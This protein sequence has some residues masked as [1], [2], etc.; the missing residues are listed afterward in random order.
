VRGCVRAY[1]G[2]GAARFYCCVISQQCPRLP[3]EAAPRYTLK[4]LL[5]GGGRVYLMSW[6]RVLQGWVCAYLM[7]WRS[8][9]RP[10][11]RPVLR[12]EQEE[13]GREEG[14]IRVE[15]GGARSARGEPSREAPRE[16]DWPVLRS[17][18]ESCSRGR[19]R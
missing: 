14:R 1:L 5:H 6:R 10:G 15:G 13:D 12:K 9:F 17:A 16:P 8:Y 18:A 2:I 4:Q 7:N 19:A 11:A 3:Q